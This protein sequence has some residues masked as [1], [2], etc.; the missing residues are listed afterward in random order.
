MKNQRPQLL[1]PVLVFSNFF[2]VLGVMLYNWTIF[3]VVYIYWIEMLI[4]STFSL[5]KIL[6]A[7]GEDISFRDRVKMGG[8]FFLIRTGI[9]FFY[10]S[11][12]VTFLGMMVSAKT[13][14]SSVDVAQT[15]ALRQGFIKLA[16]FNFIIYNLLEFYFLFI[17]NGYYK[18]AAPSKF[19]T[20]FNAR[21][22][23]VHIVVIAGTFIYKFLADKLQMNHMAVMMICVLIFAIVKTIADILSKAMEDPIPQQEGGFI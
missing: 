22:L 13:P 18:M 14:H 9:F 3:S 17:K 6:Y 12:I 7:R 4:V 8:K 15:L 16:L 5:L 1:T 21:M 19:Y 23:V 20:F 10:L 2:P 11:F